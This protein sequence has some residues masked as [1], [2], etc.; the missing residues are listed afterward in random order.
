M[1]SNLIL[2]CARKICCTK[3]ARKTGTY[4]SDPCGPDATSRLSLPLC[5]YNNTITCER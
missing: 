2:V 3:Q 1:I 4:S 5:V